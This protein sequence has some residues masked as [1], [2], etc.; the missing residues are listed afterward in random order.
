MRSTSLAAGSKPWVNNARVLREKPIFELTDAETGDSIAAHLAGPR[1]IRALAP[2]M[3]SR[4][5][6]RI[7]NVSSGWGS[8]AE[9]KGGSWTIISPLILLHG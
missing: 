7:V 8:F 1:L 5:Y 6:G 2:N 3:V 4:G 9:G